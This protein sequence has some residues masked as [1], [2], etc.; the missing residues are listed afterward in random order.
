M[1]CHLMVVYAA[2]LQSGKG[3][4]VCQYRKWASWD[5]VNKCGHKCIIC[6]VSRISLHRNSDVSCYYDNCMLFILTLSVASS[7]HSTNRTHCV[8]PLIFILNETLIYFDPHGIIIWEHVSNSIAWNWGSYFVHMWTSYVW[9]K[10]VK[11]TTFVEYLC[12]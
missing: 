8:L 1:Y 12:T 5:T 3:N 7:Q 4:S 11:C 10:I 9:S 6:K 2:V